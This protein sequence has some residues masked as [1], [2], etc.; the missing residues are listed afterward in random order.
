MKGKIIV[1]G[2][3]K[4]ASEVY[5]C[6]R[7]LQEFICKGADVSVEKN[8][9]S[10]GTNDDFAFDFALFFDKDIHLC[11]LLEKKGV[12]V[13]N[14]SDVLQKTDNKAL[15]AI[16]LQGIVD[17]PD[18]Y[19]APKRYVPDCDEFFLQ[20]TAKK[21]GYPLVV[22]ESFGSLGK[23]VFL[24]SNEKELFDIE[25]EIGVKDHIFQK[26][27]RSSY[28]QSVRVIV[29]GGQPVGAIKLSSDN[30][31]RSNAH[32]GGKAEIFDMP[33]SYTDAAKRVADSLGADYCGIDF[34]ADKPV[35]I[36][37]NGSAY[38]TE[39]ERVTGIN[40]AAKLAEYVIKKT[41]CD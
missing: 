22:K 16:A 29:I 1:N 9:Y 6:R 8:F 18:T 14:S 26:Y 13:F 3:Y 40:V 33:L 27:Y 7:L 23:Q 31:F 25:K 38:F 5:R 34:F 37:V 28:G 11:K 41:N 30:D 12:K 2:Y 10:Y 19:I 24:V 32:L 17:M 21:T 35:L 36:E 20:D 39:F 15:T 4:S